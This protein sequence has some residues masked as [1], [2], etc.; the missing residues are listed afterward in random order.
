[1]RY[2]TDN[3]QIIIMLI[4]GI[5]EGQHLME[6]YYEIKADDRSRFKESPLL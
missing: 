1:M 6:K 2:F 3:L 4:L 5:A